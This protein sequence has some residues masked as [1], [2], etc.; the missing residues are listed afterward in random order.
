MVGEGSMSGAGELFFGAPW[1][2]QM[3]GQQPDAVD[4]TMHLLNGLLYAR[5]ALRHRSLEGR[6]LTDLVLSTLNWSLWL[7]YVYSGPNP[8]KLFLKKTKKQQK[9]TCFLLSCFLLEY[10]PGILTHFWSFRN[11]FFIWSYP[12]FALNSMKK[13]LTYW[14]AHSLKY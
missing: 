13:I 7:Q 3:P 10:L 2:S 5:C 14:V 9:K 1:D 4:L 6:F 12:W 11:F 8:L